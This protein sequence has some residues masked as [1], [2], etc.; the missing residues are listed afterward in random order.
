MAEKH[1]MTVSTTR[2]AEVPRTP[3]EPLRTPLA[4]GSASR[5]RARNR[6]A[7]TAST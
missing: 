5:A 6:Q 1:A 2:Y 4:R 7:S 3:H